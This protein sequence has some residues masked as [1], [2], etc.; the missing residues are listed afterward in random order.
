MI[1]ACLT[2]GKEFQVAQWQINTGRGKYCSKECANQR[3]TKIDKVCPVCKKVF[4]VFPSESR[5]K[6]CSIECYEKT[7]HGAG[8]PNYKGKKVKV[9]CQQCGKE[10]SVYPW[11][12]KRGVKYCSFE[13]RHEA[14]KDRVIRVCKQCGKEFWTWPSA[15]R[16]G[17]GS[18][19]YCS[20]ECVKASK[21]SRVNKT[22]PTCGK[23]ISLTPRDIKGGKRFCSQSCANRLENNGRWLG[24]KSFEPYC[25]K[26]NNELKEYVRDKFDRRCFVCGTPENGRKLSVHHVDY[27][28]LQGCKG[29]TW[30]LI[31]L[32][33]SCHNKTN[34]NR[35]QWFNLLINY[36]ALNPE[37]NLHGIYNFT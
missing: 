8:N 13:C 2:C 4:A 9:L 26:F 5:I 28:K 25:Y 1:K 17:S 16:K 23:L 21:P 10:L 35:W 29:K 27:N 33:N 37:I 32:C 24:G 36:W 19:T 6:Y 18:G 3:S 11:R 22:C 34:H 20:F 15:I 12:V 31:P 14:E 7:L 30:V